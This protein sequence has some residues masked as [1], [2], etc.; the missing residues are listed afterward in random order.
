MKTPKILGEGAPIPA[1]MSAR[2][3]KVESGFA[4]DRFELKKWR[5]ISS[6]P[7]AL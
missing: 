4:S 7:L 6:L 1:R 2:S 5:M 3:A